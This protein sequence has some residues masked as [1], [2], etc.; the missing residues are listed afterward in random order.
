MARA[1]ELGLGCFETDPGRRHR[2][3][4]A[5]WW[6]RTTGERITEIT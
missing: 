1:V 6:L 3:C 4:F 5:D 2:S